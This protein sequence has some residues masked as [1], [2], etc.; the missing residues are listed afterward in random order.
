M[1]AP[2][3][4]VSSLKFAP[5]TSSRLLASCWDKN[6]YLYEIGGHGDSSETTLI[7]KFPHRGPVLDACFGKDETEAFSGGL[8]HTVQR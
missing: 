2:D 1:P 3:D 5:G 8:D 4:A 6:V 7:R